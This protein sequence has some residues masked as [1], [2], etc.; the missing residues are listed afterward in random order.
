[1]FNS[2]T[3]TF[4]LMTYFEW[5]FLDG[6]R[7]LSRFTFLGCECPPDP[8]PLWIITWLHCISLL[9]CQRPIDYIWFYLWSF[10]SA[11]LF[12]LTILSLISHYLE[13]CSLTRVKFGNR[14]MS[15][16]QLCS[17]LLITSWLFS[18]FAFHKNFVICLSIST[19]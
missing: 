11:L 18:D 13:Y 5:I 14:I 17:S 2:F 8:A 4:R 1:M 12:Y 19:K 7:S 16:L 6:I 9:L 3:F 15:V 10:N